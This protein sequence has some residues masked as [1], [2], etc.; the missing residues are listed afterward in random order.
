MS[1]SLILA[2]V[3]CI[4]ANVIGLLPSKHK[5]WP[6]AY[7]L[8]AIGVPLLGFV[9]WENGVLVGLVVLLAAA[10]ILRWP[11]LYLMRWIRRVFGI[12]AKS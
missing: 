2:C 8:M 1:W 5:H 7:I 10:S 12:P 4:L 6:S 9:I 3:W 11:L